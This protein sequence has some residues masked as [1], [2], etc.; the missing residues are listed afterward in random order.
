MFRVRRCAGFKGLGFG[1][2]LWAT[3]HFIGGGGWGRGGG[4]LVCRIHGARRLECRKE[5][6][7]NY[8]GKA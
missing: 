5:S 1:F 7:D 3:H 4:I 2:G 8:R 6:L